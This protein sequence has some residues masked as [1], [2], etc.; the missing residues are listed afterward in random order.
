M[1]LFSFTKK[2]QKESYSLVL[3]FESGAIVGAVVKFTEKPGVEISSYVREALPFQKEISP[4]RY[5]EV[6]KKSLAALLSNI[7]KSTPKGI[8][9]DKAFYIFSSPWSIS[10]TKVI[11]FKESKPFKLTESYF[12]NAIE[13]HAKN[14]TDISTHGKIIEKKIIQIKANGYVLEHFNGKSVKEA[15]VSVFL[16][17]VPDEILTSVTDIVSKYYV[18]DS[19]WCHSTS[20]AT[21]SVIRDLFSNREDFLY[22]D[23]GDEITD[24]SVVKD[25]VVFSNVSFPFGRNEFIRQLSSK[26][27]TTE[28]VADSMLKMHQQ[29]SNDELATLKFTINL[30]NIVRDWSLKIDEVMAKHSEGLYHPQTIFVVGNN[31]LIDVLVSKLKEGGTEVVPLSAKRITSPIKIEDTMFKISLTFLD[32]L[33]KI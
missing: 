6:M 16:T 11:R 21:F 17:A 9:P 2:N 10:Q 30:N 13:R 3:N 24:I 8:R 7:Q 4:A 29:K 12:K 33:Y 32:K 23:I 1:S 27:K 5:L 15:E 26:M 20:L 28:P 22:L 31:D 25:S 18:V 19:V 14:L